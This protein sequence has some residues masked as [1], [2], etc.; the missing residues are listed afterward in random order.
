MHPSRL[1]LFC[2]S[3]RLVVALCLAL[4]ASLSLAQAAQ[5]TDPRVRL[6]TSK[7]DIIIELNQ[8]KAPKTVANFLAYVKDG[9][10]DGVVFHRVIKGFM[11][12][13]G[14]LTPELDRKQTM[15]P[16]QNEADNGLKNQKYTI[17]MARTGEPHSATA[18]FFINT[19][20]NEFLNH[21]GKTPRGWGYAVF[22]KV[23]EGMDVVDAIGGVA[24]GFQA[25]RKDVPLE[26]VL[27]NKAEKVN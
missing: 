1:S 26:P 2:I 11:I 22:G 3:K 17:A 7:G 21:K 16:I 5:A 6:V 14:G 4:A 20:D 23:V 8:A 19:A 18:Q 25:G 27:I 9:F 10:F 12:Q 13:G 15:E 24:T